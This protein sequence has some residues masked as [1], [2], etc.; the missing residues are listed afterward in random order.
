MKIKTVT[1]EKDDLDNDSGEIPA[2]ILENIGSDGYYT[3]GA[4]DESKRILGMAQF[5]VG[6]GEKGH[7]EA[8]LNFIYVEDKERLKGIGNELLMDVLSILHRSGIQRLFVF[9][10]K[11]DSLE[12]LLKSSGFE[13]A[14][15]NFRWKDRKGLNGWVRP[16]HGAQP[17]RKVPAPA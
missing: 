16:T 13:I 9:A 2:E 14:G 10:G 8:G 4:V 5:C 3:I 12:A 17:K 6:T 7:T 15:T 1:L 11:S